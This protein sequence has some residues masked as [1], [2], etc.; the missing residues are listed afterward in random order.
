MNRKYDEPTMWL[1]LNSQGG[2]VGDC[3]KKH[4]VI[5]EF[6]HA[7]G[8]CHEHQ[9]SNFWTLVGPYIDLVKMKKELKLSETC[10]ALNWDSEM[11]FSSVKTKYDPRSIMH[12]W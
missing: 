9:R 10:F 4:T 8:L 12:S 6:G 2:N 5:H 1:N 3:Y 11:F 7:L